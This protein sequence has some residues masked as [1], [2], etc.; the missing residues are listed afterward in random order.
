[1]SAAYWSK[2][3]ELTR[4]IEERDKHGVPLDDLTMR[5]REKHEVR[6]ENAT[7]R[8]LDEA[9][10]AGRSDNIAEVVRVSVDSVG[11]L[12][13]KQYQGLGDSVVSGTHMAGHGAGL[14]RRDPPSVSCPV[15]IWEGVTDGC[16]IAVHP[17]R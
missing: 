11:C 14:L 9:V 12:Q 16:S 3:A 17:R 8:R 4:E 13:A 5:Q 2:I 1:M 10:E 7:M 15:C 6:L